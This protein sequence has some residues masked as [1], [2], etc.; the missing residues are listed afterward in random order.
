MFGSVLSPSH[1]LG[2]PTLFCAVTTGIGL[3]ILGFLSQFSSFLRLL[4]FTVTLVKL[5]TFPIYHCP[6]DTQAEKKKSCRHQKLTPIGQSQ[7]KDLYIF[8]EGHFIYT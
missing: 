8:Q 6:E 7:N 4:L 5:L 3:Q 2:P 1:F